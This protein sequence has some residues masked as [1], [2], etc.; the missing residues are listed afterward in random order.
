MN[1][2]APFGSDLFQLTPTQH[3]T[4]VNR[5]E[6]EVRRAHGLLR[7]LA[8]GTVNQ[9]SQRGCDEQHNKWCLGKTMIVFGVFVYLANRRVKF[10]FNDGLSKIV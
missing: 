2:P 9:I 5:R 10:A 6:N 1:T 8:A 4:W 7:A 3:D